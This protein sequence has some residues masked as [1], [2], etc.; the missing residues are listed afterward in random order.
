MGR[1]RSSQGIGA[2]E[3]E[4]GRIQ[5]GGAEKV[6]ASRAVWGVIEVRGA[7]DVG[8]AIRWRG[9]AGRRVRG[10]HIGIDVGK[11]CGGRRAGGRSR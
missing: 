4:R 3:A 2:V 9:K 6:R 7:S 11:V 10:L 5:S 8:G 1:F